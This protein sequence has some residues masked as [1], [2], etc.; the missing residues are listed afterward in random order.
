MHDHLASATKIDTSAR[1]A[2]G[3]AVEVEQGG[4]GGVGY[5]VLDSIIGLALE[6]LNEV[7]QVIA[8]VWGLVVADVLPS[9]AHAVDVVVHEGGY[10]VA[11]ALDGRVETAHRGVCLA[12]ENDLL[13]PV[14]E[15]IGH[16]ARS[17]FGAV[18]GGWIA[19]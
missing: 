17:G 19:E 2:D 9:D 7:G 18:A 8:E 14:A 13:A 12:P 6:F 3:L 11:G 10:A 5:D 4:V 16:Q 1:M 15:E